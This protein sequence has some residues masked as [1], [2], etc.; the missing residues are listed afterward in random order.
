MSGSSTAWSNIAQQLR[1][2]LG[3]GLAIH[4][5]QLQHSQSP[6]PGACREVAIARLLQMLAQNLGRQVGLFAQLLEQ[7]ACCSCAVSLFR[8]RTNESQRR[9]E[10]CLLSALRE[11]LNQAEN[12]PA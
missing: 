12:T 9:Y 3:V 7:L 10:Q 11:R 4:T 1:L 6:L 8:I 2:L 5:L